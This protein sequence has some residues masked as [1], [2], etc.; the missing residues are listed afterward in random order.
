MKT[1]SRKS[2]ASQIAALCKSGRLVLSD[3]TWIFKHVERGDYLRDPIT[4]EHFHRD[5]SRGPGEMLVREGIQNSLDAAIRNPDGTRERARVRIFISGSDAALPHESL[6]IFAE[7]AW[8][9]VHAKKNGLAHPPGKSERCR[10]LVFEDF[11]TT[12]LEGD[13]RQWRRP[14]GLNRFFHFMRAEGI[15]D[16]DDGDRGSWGVG[17][18]VFLAA[19]R[20]NA[21]LAVTRR[22]SDGKQYAMGR[23]LLKHHE[24]ADASFRPDGFFGVDEDGLAMPF[25]PN[26]MESLLGEFGVCRSESSGLSVIVPWCLDEI[27]EAGIFASV[28]REY[29][30]SILSGDLE[31]TVATPTRSF[32][33]DLETIDEA[34]RR[35]DLDVRGEFKI[36]IPLMRSAI[37]SIRSGRSIDLPVITNSGAPTWTAERIG[38][39]LADIAPRL[40]AELPV[41][42]R[43][44]IHV[45]CKRRGKLL[46][47]FTVALQ[48]DSDVGQ[49]T[50]L[51]LREGLV[52]P[53]A[54]GQRP[55]RIR[56]MAA[57]IVAQSGH[58]SELLRSAEDPSHSTWSQQTSGFKD[59]W[60]AGKACLDFVRAAPARILDLVNRE[61][62]EED[63][64]LLIDLISF[65]GESR[66][67]Q[68]RRKPRKI[69][70][71]PK[72]KKSSIVVNQIAG[73]FVISRSGDT[74]PTPCKVRVRC[75]YDRSAGDPFG[76]WCIHDFRLGEKP[77][78]VE[79]FGCGEY[80][81][82]DN[83]LV[84]N[85]VSSDDFEIRIRGFDPRRDLIIDARVTEA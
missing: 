53:G 38:S 19:S 20:A 64:D 35:C 54:S 15:T 14:E 33:I 67:R 85:F 11:G 25:D 16:K 2:V 74:D 59:K 73:G 13:V 71:P 31:V 49:F 83:I 65:T 62:S 51:C 48:P 27:T 72:K 26:R 57:I 45:N 36:T 37:D 61:D 1:T 84:A 82:Y 4:T 9:H 42:I 3:P 41:T 7:S 6:G 8:P 12:G 60:K 18:T 70:S 47:W 52:V 75:A 32:V 76:A 10:Y 46:D 21:I 23:I 5:D 66:G 80:E 40:R 17:K 34:V 22:Q 56:G 39:A 30:F 43:V 77:I 69:D 78:E 24:I 63:A 58:L 50:P 79:V 29:A 28:I 68:R 44:P 81:A 55:P